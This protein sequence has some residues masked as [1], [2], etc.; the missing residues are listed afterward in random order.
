MDIVILSNNIPFLTYSADELKNVNGEFHSSCFVEEK[1]GVD[2]V[3][4]RAAL[5]ACGEKGRLVYEK[6]AEDGM[7]I[8]RSQNSRPAACRRDAGN[9][10]KLRFRMLLSDF[11][12]QGGHPIYSRIS[13]AYKSSPP[14]LFRFRKSHSA[15]FFFPSHRGGQHF[16]M[17]EALP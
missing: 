1:T 2:N 17:T 14:S 13:A 6:H 9:Y 15:A 12:H 11:I 4:E 3:C 7:T 16:L 5:K 10:H 8:R